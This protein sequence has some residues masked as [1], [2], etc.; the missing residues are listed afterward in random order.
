MGRRPSPVGYSRLSERLH[1]L[2][3]VL[4]AHCTHT[5]TPVITKLHIQSHTQQL[6]Q[7][8][9]L[10]RSALTSLIYEIVKAVETNDSKINK[11]I[12]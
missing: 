7:I 5:R 11:C 8:A 2:R 12:N 1:R 3:Y 4:D 6:P 9:A 10:R